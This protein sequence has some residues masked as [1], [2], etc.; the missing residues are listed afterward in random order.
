MARAL[1]LD[2]VAEGVENEVQLA[3]LRARL[4]HAQGHLFHAAIFPR[5]VWRMLGE[6]ASRY[7]GIFAEQVLVGE[8]VSAPAAPRSVRCPTSGRR[9]CPSGSV[10]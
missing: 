7:S 10:S 8:Q 3:E 6:G 1:W 2:V 9:R 5:E 4:R